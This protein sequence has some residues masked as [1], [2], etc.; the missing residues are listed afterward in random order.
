MLQK[1]ASFLLVNH[2]TALSP[3]QD[4][5][6]DHKKSQEVAMTLGFHEFAEFLIGFAR[7]LGGCWLLFVPVVSNL[8]EFIT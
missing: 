2:G 1:D 7:F 8:D 4:R 6:L 3:T 5:Y